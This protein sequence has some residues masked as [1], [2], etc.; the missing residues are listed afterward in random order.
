MTARIGVYVN[1]R[2][3]ELYGGMQVQH[4]LISY[5]PAVYAACKRGELVICDEHGFR[6]GL[7]GGLHDGA[8][9]F[10]KSP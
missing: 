8:H 1:D 4:A 2:R 5:D 7:E 3:I 9:L 6:V 10:V